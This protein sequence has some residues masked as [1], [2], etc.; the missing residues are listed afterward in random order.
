MMNESETLKTLLHVKA[1]I[2]DI[3]YKNVLVLD[4]KLVVFIRETFCDQTLLISVLDGEVD[5]EGRQLFEVEETFF[6]S[7]SNEIISMNAPMPEKGIVGLVNMACIGHKT[8]NN[9]R[10]K[11]T[12][13]RMKSFMEQYN[14]SKEKK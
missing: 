10:N 7:E 12:S 3:P 9:S 13:L 6:Y 5:S 8:R 1:E 4:G 2:E 14:G 11:T